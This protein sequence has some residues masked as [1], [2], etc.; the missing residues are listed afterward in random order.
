MWCRTLAAHAKLEMH[1]AKQAVQLGARSGKQPEDVTLT[2]AFAFRRKREKLDHIFKSKPVFERVTGPTFWQISLRNAY[3]RYVPVGH[4][5]SGAR[6]C[7]M[8]RSS[9]LWPSLAC[10]AKDMSR[11]R[12]KACRAFHGDLRAATGA[13]LRA[14][15]DLW[16][17]PRLRSSSQRRSTRAW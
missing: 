14:A 8:T 10:L 9:W 12:L 7:R 4:E 15:R 2:R 16:Q 13:P 17:A 11:S 5:F 3:A 6:S 1:W